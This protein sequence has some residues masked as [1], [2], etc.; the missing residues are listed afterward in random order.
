MSPKCSP[1]KIHFL[2]LDGARRK[3]QRAR[4]ENAVETSLQLNFDV[5]GAPPLSMKKERAPLVSTK[6]YRSGS[7]MDTEEEQVAKRLRRPG[8]LQN[9][10]SRKLSTSPFIAKEVKIDLNF[11]QKQKKKTYTEEQVKKIVQRALRDQEEKLREEYD[12]ILGE[13]LAEQFENFTNFN[14]DY[15]YRQMNRKACSYVS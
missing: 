3:R 8:D 6:R 9:D 2:S 5:K 10:S 12:R 14:Q 11:G 1:G 13:R 15:V 7:A 4:D